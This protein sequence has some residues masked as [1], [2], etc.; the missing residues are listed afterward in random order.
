MFRVLKEI[1]QD[2]YNHDKRIWSPSQLEIIYNSS[3]DRI[4]FKLGEELT[5]NKN[6]EQNLLYFID[7]YIKAI[8][9]LNDL[10]PRLSSA[11]I[12]YINTTALEEEIALFNKLR[13][14]L[15][16]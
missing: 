8:P 4:K 12:N 9:L 7:T 11:V 14:I 2:F 6:T 3:L 10:K 16:K 15:E 13:D 1:K 5:L